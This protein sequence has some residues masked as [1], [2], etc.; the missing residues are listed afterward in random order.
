MCYKW[1]DEQI[2]FKAISSLLHLCLLAEHLGPLTL[3]VCRVWQA[4]INVFFM[5]KERKR[6]ICK[7]QETSTQ[8]ILNCISQQGMELVCSLLLQFLFSWGKA[9]SGHWFA[10]D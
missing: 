3:M 8:V 5:H 9:V 10:W 4:P 2:H 1:V 6:A 7:R